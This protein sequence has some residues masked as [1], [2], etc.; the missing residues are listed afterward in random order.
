MYAIML[1]QNRPLACWKPND[2]LRRSPAP[3]LLGAWLCGTGITLLVFQGC[4]YTC[5]HQVAQ[6]Q[7][8]AGTG[9]LL[10]KAQTPQGSYSCKQESTCGLKPWCSPLDVTGF[11]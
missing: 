7:L 2:H 10:R 1:Q 9:L 3:A 5:I 6:L 11:K 4:I 8:Q